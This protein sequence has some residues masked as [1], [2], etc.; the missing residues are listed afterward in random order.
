MSEL[1]ELID[2]VETW[3][4]QRTALFNTPGMKYNEG[5][6]YASMQRFVEIQD[7]MT[8]RL[9]SVCGKQDPGF[10]S[11]M[12]ELAQNTDRIIRGGKTFINGQQQT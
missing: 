7:A 2:V 11:A 9:I 5:S 12:Y 8:K 1:T 4:I 3:Q 10:Y 6:N